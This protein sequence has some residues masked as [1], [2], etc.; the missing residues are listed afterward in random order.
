MIKAYNGGAG[1]IFLR[2]VHLKYGS[3][4]M[5][6]E[7]LRTLP[8]AVGST[9]QMNMKQLCLIEC[10]VSN[11][12]QQH[13][14]WRSLRWSFY[15]APISGGNEIMA[16]YFLNRKKLINEKQFQYFINIKT[17]ISKFTLVELERLL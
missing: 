12:G 6:C 17:L 11:A 10:R 5:F 9:N 2:D 16:Y 4:P 15:T 8:H 1:I 7:L 13:T 14:Y 3:N